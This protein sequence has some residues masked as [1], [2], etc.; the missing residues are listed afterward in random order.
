MAWHGVS[1]DWLTVMHLKL[2]DAERWRLAGLWGHLLLSCQTAEVEADARRPPP[3][4][5]PSNNVRYF[6]FSTNNHTAV[7]HL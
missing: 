4:H 3:F 2:C 6:S 1:A 5:K 7:A